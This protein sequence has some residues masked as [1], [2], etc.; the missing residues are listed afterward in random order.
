MSSC[1]LSI[2]NLSSPPR[3]SSF[4]CDAKA[5]F[6]WAGSRG[7]SKIVTTMVEHRRSIPEKIRC[8]L[9]QGPIPRCRRRE[10]PMSK[11]KTAVVSTSLLVFHWTKVQLLPSICFIARRKETKQCQWRERFVVR[12]LERIMFTHYYIYLI[13]I[14][15]NKLYLFDTKSNV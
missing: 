10:A 12:G 3:I 1:S 4:L 9:P 14:Y 11:I 5:R 8:R 2:G 15:E 7:T 13:Y 6:G